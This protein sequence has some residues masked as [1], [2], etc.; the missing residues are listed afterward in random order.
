MMP[1]EDRHLRAIKRGVRS[2][3]VLRVALASVILVAAAVF[4]IREI[5]AAGSAG[6]RIAAATQSAAEPAGG[7]AGLDPSALAG[8]WKSASDP[9]LLIVTR[10]GDVWSD[11]G[12]LQGAAMPVHAGVNF[13]FGNGAFSCA[14]AIELRGSDEAD[15]H[16]ID[17]TGAP[18]CPSGVFRR[19]NP[20]ASAYHPVAHGK[21]TASSP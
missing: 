7:V 14:Y 17:R 1:A 2:G 5:R 3:T 21:T 13:A 12:G 19:L 6:L 18:T 4:G 11:R 15:W 20:L 8:D 10:R 9:T 16:L